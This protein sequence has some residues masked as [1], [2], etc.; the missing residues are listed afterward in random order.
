MYGSQEILSR[1]IHAFA[2]VHWKWNGVYWPLSYKTVTADWVY[3]VYRSMLWLQYS[4]C[5]S[6]IR[7]A[8]FNP[9]NCTFPAHFRARAT[10]FCSGDFSASNSVIIP[11]LT[12]LSATA[13]HNRAYRWYFRAQKRYSV[14][15]YPQF[16]HSSWSAKLHRLPVSFRCFRDIALEQSEPSFCLTF[17]WLENIST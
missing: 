9:P 16:S 14:R 2:L 3:Q 15:S 17:T 7:S 10:Y 1:Q 12:S 13:K 8:S 11:A 6:F 5:S 4:L